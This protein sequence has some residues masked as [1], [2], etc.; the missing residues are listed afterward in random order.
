MG[1]IM[2]LFLAFIVAL[3]EKPVGYFD[4][5][6]LEC[7]RAYAIDGYLRGRD[8][9]PIS[10]PGHCSTD[11]L[12]LCSGELNPRC[13]FEL[14]NYNTTIRQYADTTLKTMNL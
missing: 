8:G 10:P 1:A 6:R 11:K 4:T 7:K 3:F 5:S 13:Q 12:Y 9:R 14:D 2:L